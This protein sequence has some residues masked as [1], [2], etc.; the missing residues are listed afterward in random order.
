MNHGGELLVTLLPWVTALLVAFAIYDELDLPRPRPGWF[1]G[2]Y[3][4]SSSVLLS[5]SNC[6]F[7]P[8][9]NQGMQTGTYHCHGA[10]PTPSVSSGLTARCQPSLSRHLACFARKNL[11]RTSPQT[12]QECGKISLLLA[13]IITVY[14]FGRAIQGVLQC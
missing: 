9:P 6:T 2:P 4:G 14:I 7:E 8:S 10:M 13:V 1:I 3:S 5:F 11:T 12:F